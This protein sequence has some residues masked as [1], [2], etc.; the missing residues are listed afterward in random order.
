MPRLILPR[1]QGLRLHCGFNLHLPRPCGTYK[2]EVRFDRVF[3]VD[4]FFAAA[5]EAGIYL[6]ARPGPYVSAETAPGRTARN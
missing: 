1:D 2:G 6:I 5:A 3:V 4:A